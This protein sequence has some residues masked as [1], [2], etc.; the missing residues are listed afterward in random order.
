M[1]IICA[2][3]HHDILRSLLREYRQLDIVIVEKGFDYEGLCY[4]FSMEHTEDLVSYLQS[5]EEKYVICLELDQQYKLFPHQIYFIEGY[6]NEAFVHT[7]QK[8]YCIHQKLYE[9]EEKLRFYGFIRINK[10]TLVNLHHIER[11]IP[12]VQRRYVLILKNQKRLLLTR[13]Y[14]KS[15]ME[16][17]RRNAL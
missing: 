9:L 17:L 5:L 4:Y 8:E 6:S 13:Y 11:I 3:D 1:K 15:F 7:D 12:E 16:E 14:V 2:P 10:S